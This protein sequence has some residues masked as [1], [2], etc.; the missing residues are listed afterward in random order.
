MLPKDIKVTLETMSDEELAKKIDQLT[1][2]LNI[3]LV[4]LAPK[5]IELDSHVLPKPDHENEHS[6]KTE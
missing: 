1:S 2:S 6:G 3:K 4:P 5:T